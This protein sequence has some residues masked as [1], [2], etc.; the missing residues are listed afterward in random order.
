MDWKEQAAELERLLPECEVAVQWRVR[1]QVERLLPPRNPNPV[2][3]KLAAF[4]SDAKASV[5]RCSKLLDSLPVISFPEAL[6]ISQHRDEIRRTIEENQVV[7]IAGETG[8]GKTTQLPKL[9]LDAGRGVMGKI[10][11]T[12]P[13]R[14][15]ALSVSQRVAEELKVSWGKEVGAKIRFTDKTGK[16]T[17]IKFLTDGMLLSEIHG[18]RHL[19]E[20][21]T[22]IIDEAHERSLNIDFLLGYLNQLRKERPDLK[23]IITSATIDTEAFSKAFGDAPIIEVSG[24]MFPVDLEYLPLDE[25]LPGTSANYLDGAVAAVEQLI[26]EH[27]RGDIL[28]FFPAEK[29]IRETRDVLIGR[30]WKHVEVFTLFGRLSSGDQQKVFSRSGGRKIILSTNIAETSLT[31]PGIRFVVDTGYV[32]LSRYSAG[33]RTQRLPIEEVSQSSANQ[34][35]GR[36]GRVEN[37]ICIRLYSEAD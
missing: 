6:P 28:V 26:E 8:S 12:Q 11:C 5:K 33:T 14:I 1:E 23:I 21:D 16:D 15:A 3:K 30:R 24:R 19:L 2:E 18:D 9:C 31:I 25:L 27:N 32:R 22:V 29:D 17:R 7:V 13:R 37:G 36:C 34:R 20:Y 35:M 10:A 4:L